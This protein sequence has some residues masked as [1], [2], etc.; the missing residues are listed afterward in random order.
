MQEADPLLAG[1]A[2]GYGVNQMMR[3]PPLPARQQP[4]RFGSRLRGCGCLLFIL[5]ALAGPFI[6]V[7]LTNGTLHLIF[8]YIAAGIVILFFLLLLIGMFAT[9]SG[10]EALSEGCLEAILGGFFG[11]G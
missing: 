8:M 7:A 3:Q 4:R 5:A 1:L 10:R 9:R 11:G 6:G 2:A